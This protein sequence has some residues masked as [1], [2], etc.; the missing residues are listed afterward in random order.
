MKE[1][2]VRENQPTN[3]ALTH[4]DLSLKISPQEVRRE[5]EPSECVGGGRE[6]GGGRRG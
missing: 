5:S 4:Q 2:S 3:E 1:G 6:E